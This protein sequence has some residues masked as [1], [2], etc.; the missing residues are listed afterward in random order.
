MGFPFRGCEATAP[1]KPV[2]SDG[3][4]AIVMPAFRG[5]E[6]TAPLKPR[7]HATVHELAHN[8]SVA[9]KPRPH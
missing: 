2:Y 9:A 1:L 3:W 6:A 7:F 4:I 5:C 8:P